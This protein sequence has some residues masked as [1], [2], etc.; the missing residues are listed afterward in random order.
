[1][2]SF[3]KSLVDQCTFHGIKPFSKRVHFLEFM[4]SVFTQLDQIRKQDPKKD[5]FAVLSRSILQD[6]PVLCLDEFQVLDIGSA[7]ILRRLFESLY[8]QQQQEHPLTLITTTNKHIESL[9]AKGLNR[10]AVKPFLKLLEEKC[11]TIVLEGGVDYRKSGIQKREKRVFYFPDGELFK[12]GEE[13]GRA[14]LDRFGSAGTRTTI[15][16]PYGRSLDVQ[17]NGTKVL[18]P[19]DKLCGNE[20][21]LGG[22]DYIAICRLFEQVFVSGPVQKFDLYGV[23]AAGVKSVDLGRRFINFIDVSYDSR[24]RVV[25]E[26]VAG[27]EDMLG[28]LE[29][30][31]EQKMV[32]EIE[33][34]IVNE[35]GSSSSGSTTYVG[36]MEWSA[37]GLQDASLGKIGG[38]G[39]SETVFAVERAISRV[40]EMGSDNWK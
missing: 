5:A 33:T 13:S 10:S 27:V 34:R 6:T 25:V 1:M 36:M 26:A 20:G 19:F 24:V 35:G 31:D 16:L 38:V 11:E 37:T 32:K 23:D 22:A 12:N 18:I 29:T 40:I 14:F 2:D 39:I 8:D 21:K 9:Y 4:A 28:G 7:L 30:S 15:E 3:H 17:V